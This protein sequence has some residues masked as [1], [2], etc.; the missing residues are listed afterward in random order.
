[1]L[2]FDCWLWIV[3]VLCDCRWTRCEVPSRGGEEDSDIL[4]R[5]SHW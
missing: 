2:G 3:L 5:H 4:F 1:M